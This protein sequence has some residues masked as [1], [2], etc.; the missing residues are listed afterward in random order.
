[1]QKNEPEAELQRILKAVSRSFYLSMVWLPP[2]MRRGIAL[3]YLLARAAD[4][5]ADTSSAP[6]AER[7]AALGRARRRQPSRKPS[8]KRASANCCCASIP[9]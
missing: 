9:A 6:A 2:A 5:V 8:R 3:G 7:V 1:M 4:S